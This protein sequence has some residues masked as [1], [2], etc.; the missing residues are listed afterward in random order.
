M[1][2]ETFR[3]MLPLYVVG[4]LD[5]DELHNFE[6]YVAENRERCVR[7]LTEYQ[8]VADQIALAAPVAKPSPGLYDRIAA[9]VDTGKHHAPAPAAVAVA[10][11]A[12]RTA[13]AGSRLGWLI[14][15]L[16]PWA[17]AAVLA[18]LP[19]TG[20]TSQDEAQAAGPKVV[21]DAGLVTIKLH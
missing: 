16:I 6:R 19:G 21:E 10:A 4:A 2:H 11:P 18:D 12:R 15:R 20:K 7:E 1:T 3:E 8:A 13:P 17:A 14:V 5:G 9:T